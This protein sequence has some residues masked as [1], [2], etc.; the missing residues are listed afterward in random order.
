MTTIY[1]SVPEQAEPR[2]RFG[3]D[4]LKQ[5]L[6]KLG[7]SVQETGPLTLTSYRQL[8]GIKI[9]VGDRR[10]CPFIRELEEHEVL[11]YHKDAP[12]GEGFYLAKLPGRLFVVAGGGD[13]G[14][15][16]GCQELA[17]LLADKG[18][19]PDE[20]AFGD[21]PVMKLRGPVV[22]LQKTKVE[23][24]RRTYEYPIT[25]DRFPW[26]YDKALWEAFLD[27]LLE[28]RCNVI[29]IWTGH[30]FSSLVKLEDYPEALEVT[31]EEFSRNAEI[32]QWLAEQC[33][34]RGIWLVLKFYNI[35]IPLPFAEK[36]GLDLHQPQPLPITSD[37]HIQAISAFIRS[38]PNVGLMVCLGE[39]LQG[40][41]Y[42]VEWFNETILAG[43]KEG[44]K[45][46]DRK[47]LPP[48][49]VRAHA[50]PSEKVMEAALPNY[51]NLYTEAKFNGESLTTFTPRGN[52]QETHRHLGSLGSVHLFNVH[53]LANLEPFRFGA[54]SF[55][56]KCVQAAKYRLGTNGI[57]LYPLFYW[58]W[59]Y[60]PDKTTPR[61]LQMERD[62]IW[63]SAWFRYAWN[64]DLSPKLEREYWINELAGR[65]GSRE[66]GEAIL[67]AYEASGECA[68][69]LLR[70]FGITEGNRQ[71][72]S[73]GMTMSQL[74]NPERYRP[75][76]ELWESQSPQGERLEQYVER[77]LLGEAHIGETPVDIADNVDYHADKAVRA[78]GRAKAHVTRGQ[79]EFERIASDVSAIALMTRS[80]THKVRAAIRI[81][82]YKSMSGTDFLA[83]AE[84]L[85]QA[86][87]DF[88]K[89]L[90]YYRELAALTDNTYLYA[91][92]M[93]TPQR[94][95][96]F[97][98]GEKYGHWRAC[99]PMYEEE[100]ANFSA[101]VEQLRQSRLPRKVLESERDIVPYVQAGF[102]LHS[103]HAETYE[104]RNQAKLFTDGEILASQVAEELVGLTG[105][106]L[107]REQAVKEGVSLEIELK[108]P[109]RVLV[110]YFNS[111]DAEWLKVP[112]LEENTH[113]DDRGGLSPVIKNG[114]SV[115]FYPNV[116]VHAFAYEPGRHTIV[117]G[118][119]AYLIV[120][121]IKA[122]QPLHVRDLAG[123][124]SVDTLDWLYEN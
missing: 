68:P 90:H 32:F 92:S 99:L 78:I 87:P 104:V 124:S 58:D 97:P 1:L 119:G 88:R 16:Y 109:A 85:E 116:N 106:R 30:P 27:R 77:E 75:W 51:E 46:L 33:D 120:G 23:P 66:A 52:W 122:D 3:T 41:L 42:G 107:S 102:T 14:A 43:V 11:L 45:D 95:V 24:P 10:Y 22:P 69:K 67:D 98:D 38:Y 29:Y 59:P 19:L 39:A 111:A 93:Q 117:F 110:G 86:L 8:E 80:Y 17:A 54:P 26:F 64:P 12:E 83:H 20:L 21:A 96:P 28:Q 121:I 9:A 60:S 47:E 113:A 57:H 53:I 94:R 6:Q 84:L 37:Y 71:T 49:I 61:Q 63:F 25:P 115:F 40:A 118:Q 70:R 114:V 7:F 72:M 50:I 108:E 101:N 48:I 35:H 112:N 65:Y 89:S 56:Q 103:P 5:S 82:T 15:L 44:L 100:Y 2:I 105:I 73:L 76:K 81:L 18:E 123:A 31:E 74:T 34:C 79:E 36:H 55:I 13:T 62:W 4:L 91:N